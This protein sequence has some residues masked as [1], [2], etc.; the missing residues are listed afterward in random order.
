MI[1]PGRIVSGAQTG[2]DRAA[3]DF[4]IERGIAWGGWAPKGWRSEDGAIP[5]RYREHMRE[6]STANYQSRTWLNVDE[7]TATMLVVDERVPMSP[8]TRLTIDLARKAVRSRDSFRFLIANLAAP[9][10]AS[11]VL[12]WQDVDL[13]TVNIAGPRESKAPGI[14]QATLSLLREVWP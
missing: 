2:V 4:A 7:S 6:C 1:L 13:S 3:L 8:G 5:E 14:Y 10:A 9:D 11:F 12:D